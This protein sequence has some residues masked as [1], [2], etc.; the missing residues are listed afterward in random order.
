MS[1]CPENFCRTSTLTFSNPGSARTI[2][3][4]PNIEQ[5][6]TWMFAIR[7]RKMDFKQSM[8][9]FCNE[10]FVWQT[11]NNSDVVL[12]ASD[13]QPHNSSRIPIKSLQDMVDIK[14]AH[15]N[16][17]KLMRKKRL[18]PVIKNKA[19]LFF[20]WLLIIMDCN[21]NNG[22]WTKSYYCLIS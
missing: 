13:F 3:A 18:P 5:I 9:H 4:V 12:S 17:R 8:F 6:K 15:A 21:N 2:L 20:F 16:R 10:P 7:M 1:V 11:S 22:N 19:F 14:K